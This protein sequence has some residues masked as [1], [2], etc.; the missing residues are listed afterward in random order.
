MTTCI[1]NDCID[2]HMFDKNYI[3]KDQDTDTNDQLC[4]HT[5]KT[6]NHNYDTHY[7][8]QHN[9]EDNSENNGEK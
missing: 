2:D 8:Y 9:D 4:D 1:V 3:N 6:S 7:T 5:H